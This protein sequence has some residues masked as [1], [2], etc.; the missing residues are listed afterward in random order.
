MPLIIEYNIPIP[1]NRNLNKS[2][3]EYDLGSELVKDLP[4]GASTFVIG[5]NPKKLSIRLKRVG[6]G[7]SFSVMKS[8][9]DGT[10]GY[11]VYRT[12]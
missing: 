6:V 4:I 2:G 8:K 10:E 12:A 3:K 5:V 11:R 1:N 9:K 7:M